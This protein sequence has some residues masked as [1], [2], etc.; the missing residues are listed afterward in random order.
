MSKRLI[1]SMDFP[2]DKGGI[3]NYVYGIASNLDAEK[4]I[5]LCDKTENLTQAE[6]FD[7]QQKFK[8]IRMNLKPSVS[9]FNKI[10]NLLL[11]AYTIYAICRKNKIEEVHFGN[12]FP[13]GIAGIIVKKITKVKIVPYIHG[14]DVLSI[15]KKRIA[16][17]LLFRILSNSDKII[18]NSRFTQNIITDFGIEE[19]KLCIINPGINIPLENHNSSKYVNSKFNDLKDSIVLLTVARLVERKGHDNV[20]KAISEIVPHNKNIKYL[21]C[22]DGPY[23]KNL[24]D[25]VNSLGLQ[26]NVIFTGEVSNEE[27]EHIYNISNIFIMPSRTIIEKGDVEGYGIVFLEANLH[28]LPVIAGNSG[29]VPDAVLD[30]KTGYLVDP[31]NPSEISEKI[32]L[33]IN[34]QDVFNRI[35]KYGYEWVKGNCS[36]ENRV[37]KIKE[38]F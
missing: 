2:P 1:V 33:L 32:N 23:K 27:L 5:V 21:I 6:E 24:N 25:M 17:S 18:C 3:Q 16:N 34:N 19:S 37:K 12:V 30:G 28:K 11:L 7:S 22:G 20:L 29:G 9:I 35:S 15:R 36:W 4:T 26:N 14:L 10:I 31:L 38:L 8:I 13:I